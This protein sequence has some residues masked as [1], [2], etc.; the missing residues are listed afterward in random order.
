M[1]LNG[2]VLHGCREKCYETLSLDP[3]FL[4]VA[5]LFLDIRFSKKKFYQTE[6]FFVPDLKY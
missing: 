6:S 4:K 3:L 1:I 2:S 5:M